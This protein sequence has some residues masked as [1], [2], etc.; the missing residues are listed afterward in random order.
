ML[1]NEAMAGPVDL[2]REASDRALAVVEGVAAGQWDDPTPCTEW[3]VRA[4]VDHLVGGAAYLQGALAGRAPEP[5]TG[6]TAADYRARLAEVREGAP[7]P[8]ALARVCTSP[9][10]FEWTAAEAFAGTF[11]DTLI[12]TWD[13]ATATGQDATLDPGL[14]A[15]CTALFLPEMPERG[16]AAGIIGPAVPVG[17][18]ASPQD[19]L[20]AAMGRHP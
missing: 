15:A 14:V 4:L 11:M 8:V 2:Y 6:A 7:D 1:N 12:H 5:V 9:L 18:D 19:R 16:R 17:A 20:L 13:L 3:D 10:G